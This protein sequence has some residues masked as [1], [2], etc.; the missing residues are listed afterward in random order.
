MSRHLNPEWNP[1]TLAPGLHVVVGY[2]VV[3]AAVVD[4][5]ADAGADVVVITRSGRGPERADVQR[6]AVDVA[7]SAAFTAAVPEAAVLYN[8]VNPPNYH[9][10]SV[11]WPPMAAA[12]LA[13]AEATGAVLV[14]C[15][16][17]YGYG[18]TS[19]PMA[20]SL[21]LAAQESKGR[22][23]AQMWLDAKSLHDA[24]RI[25]ATEVRGSDYICAGSQSR[26][27]D[28]VVPRVLAGRG[29]QLLGSLDQPHSWTAPV[30]VAR[31]MIVAGADERAWGRAW[32]VPSNL[33]RT[34]AEAVADIASAAGLANVK[35]SR[36]PHVVESLIGLFVPPVKELKKVAY[37]MDHPYVLDDR[38]AR[39]TFGLLPTPYAD[40][41]TD[42]V[43]AYRGSSR[44]PV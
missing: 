29:V 35:V 23:R 21:P 16:N 4:L 27:G 8:C 39:E 25:R 9:L 2:G 20:E 3:G 11:E 1:G 18:P 43:D 5:L 42:L 10:W 24:G 36:I 12:F 40:V 15:S 38:A 34:Q 28:R 17:L 14:T 6:L 44:V 33:P 30:D 22:V 13:V 41:L 32:H 26:L 31:L 7:D 37:Q 19:G